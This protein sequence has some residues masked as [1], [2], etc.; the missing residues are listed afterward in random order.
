MQVPSA[1][2]LWEDVHIQNWTYALWF[3]PNYGVQT[4]KNQD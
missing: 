1:H 3:A 4:A 2:I